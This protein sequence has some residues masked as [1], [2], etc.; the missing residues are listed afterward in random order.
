MVWR[1]TDVRSN[2]IIFLFSAPGF[3][4]FLYFRFLFLP[5]FSSLTPQSW[6]LPPPLSR[7][8]L[9]YLSQ[10]SCPLLIFSSMFFLSPHP[11]LFPLCPSPSPSF[12]TMCPLHFA[13][14]SA[15]PAALS[16]PSSLS[17]PV[18]RPPMLP[19]TSPP[20]TLSLCLMEVEPFLGMPRRRPFSF[21]PCCSPEGNVTPAASADGC[22]GLPWQP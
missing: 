14:I 19:P 11:P 17:P 13:N 15:L 9:F 5:G 10:C 20:H 21:C 12:H 7:W 4:S 18:S 2:R 16:P 22:G 1:A 6:S 8:F 3:L